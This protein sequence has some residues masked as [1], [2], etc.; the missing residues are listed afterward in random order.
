MIVACTYFARWLV[1]LIWGLDAAADR[2]RT[3]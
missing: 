2:F 1:G 3:H